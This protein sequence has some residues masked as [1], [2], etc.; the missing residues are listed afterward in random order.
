MGVISD[1]F[2][3]NFGIAVL[4]VKE[5]LDIFDNSE[6]NDPDWDSIE[7]ETDID[8]GKPDLDKAK[9]NVP[10]PP[11]VVNQHFGDRDRMKG[12]IDVWW[13]FDDGG[14]TILIPYLLTNHSFWKDCTLR[15]FTQKSSKN[16]IQSAKL[17]MANLLKKF[18][19]EFSSIVELDGINQQ[20]SKGSISEYK[21]LPVTKEAFPNGAK[22]DVNTLRQIRLGE[23]LREH[24]SDARLVVVTLPVART[25]LVPP[26]VYMSWLEVLSADLPPT[27]LIRGNQASV[28]TF[29]S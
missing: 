2:D 6:E 1:A 12:T 13:L 7:E 15:I 3:L 11:I 18:R 10:I 25:S 22:L 4:R 17:R 23:L 9:Q 26:L 14:L 29:Y 19:I 20:P 24:S 8:V 16:T 5:G 28:L 27:V 21:N